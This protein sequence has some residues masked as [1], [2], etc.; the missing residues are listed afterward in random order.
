MDKLIIT[1]AICG[2]DSLL[3]LLKE[4]PCVPYERLA[5]IPGKAQHHLRAAERSA[6]G[7]EAAHAYSEC[8]AD[9][10]EFVVGKA[11]LIP[12]GQKYGLA[13]IQSAVL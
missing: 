7:L 8:C 4:V 9:F 13:A 3:E 5:V 11:G 2:A 10:F 1:A 12:E 6:G